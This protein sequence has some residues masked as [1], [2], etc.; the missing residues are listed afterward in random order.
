[1]GCVLPAGVDFSGL[2]AREEAVLL[3]LELGELLAIVVV[4][5][6]VGNTHLTPIDLH[7]SACFTA[8]QANVIL[9]LINPLT[10]HDIRK[11][12]RSSGI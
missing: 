3:L 5:V 11:F 10:Y 1:V 12:H 9:Q 8:H 7:L 6:L 4:V 2:E